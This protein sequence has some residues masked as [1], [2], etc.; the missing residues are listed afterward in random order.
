MM[1]YRVKIVPQDI[2]VILMVHM[3]VI[4]FHVSAMVMLKHVIAIQEYVKI[5]NIT[6]QENIVMNVLKDI[7][8]MQ[9]L[10]HHMIV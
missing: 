5:V 2:I 7:M 3:E 8:E 9:Q 6:Q 10:E 1:D 4:V